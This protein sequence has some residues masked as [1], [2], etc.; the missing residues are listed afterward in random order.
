MPSE[1]LPSVSLL[2]KTAHP[3]KSYTVAWALP[4]VL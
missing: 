4:Q 2:L 3:F 1:P